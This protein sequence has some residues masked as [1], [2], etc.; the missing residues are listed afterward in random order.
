MISKNESIRL[1]GIAILMM[2]FLHLFNT[3]E[4]IAL[5]APLVYVTD[6]KPLVQLLTRV[7]SLCVPIYVFI[8]GYG[9][10]YIYE[11]ADG[12]NIRI[13]NR[14]LRIYAN[15]WVII[16]LFVPIGSIVN[17][18]LYPGN[19]ITFL[20]NFSGISYSYNHEWWFLMPYIILV[21]CSS[22]IISAA[23]KLDKRKA[24]N[25]G[26]GM[27]IFYIMLRLL[28][29]VVPV[30]PGKDFIFNLLNLLFPFFAGII[31]AH[32]RILGRFRN[33]ITNRWKDRSNY[34]LCALL[35]L[36]CS[37]R[38]AIKTSTFDALYALLLITL[39]TC[40]N[41]PEWSKHTLEKVGK[42]STNMWLIHTFYSWYFFSD[43]FYGLRYPLVMFP[44]LVVVS[45]GTSALI[46]KIYD[47][48]NRR[49]LSLPF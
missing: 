38:I 16:L 49:I 27:I 26:I 3:N 18:E 8:S 41:L 12:K 13:A 25:W 1:K 35:F 42:Q 7:A 48:L 19:L 24:I 31:F 21:L 44:A 32:H 36:V 17:P 20:L 10:S 40:I 28:R 14:I 46:H 15:Y 5:C 11:K 4:R 2:L 33:F 39:L 30:F 34:Y 45:Y 37:L 43:F 6:G 22:H 29:G 9:L 47:P 23:H